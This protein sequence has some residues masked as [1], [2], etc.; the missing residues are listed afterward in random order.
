MFEKYILTSDYLTA[1]LVFAVSVLVFRVF[2]GL[3][4]NRLKKLSKRTKTDID[5]M[6]IG[7]VETLRPPF[8]FFLAFYIAL[9]FLEINRTLDKLVD[10][11][12]VTW[13]VY[14]AAVAVQVVIDY[15]IG[16]KVHREKE[17]GAKIAYR[18]IG[19]LAKVL[20]WTAAILFALSNLG[21]NITSLVAGL[22]IGGNSAS[23][24]S[25]KGA[26]GRYRS[27]S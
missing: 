14:Q 7:I 3:V 13:V 10:V 22:G 15:G 9:G 24:C 8:Y 18:A 1:L 17:S 25:L 6:L 5:D 19:K 2:Q 16:K 27:K 26:L 20:V 11:V 23:P 12:L 21:V 4:L